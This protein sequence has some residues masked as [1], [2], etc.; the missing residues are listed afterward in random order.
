MSEDVA[1][2]IRIAWIRVYWFIGFVTNLRLISGFGFGF[3][4]VDSSI[5]SEKARCGSAASADR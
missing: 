3:C 1:R 5:P 2:R 4:R